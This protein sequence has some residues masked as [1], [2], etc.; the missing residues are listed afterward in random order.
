[1]RHL[2]LLFLPFLLVLL[3]SPALADYCENSDNGTGTINLPPDCPTGYMCNAGGTACLTDCSGAAHGD[4]ISDY[5]CDS[6]DDTC[7]IRVIE[8]VRKAVEPDD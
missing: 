1:M 7:R 5:W 3:A 8:E 4:C 6:T 2:K